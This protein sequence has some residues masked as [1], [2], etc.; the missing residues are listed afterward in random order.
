MAY[1]MLSY[2]SRIAIASGST[3]NSTTN[4][5]AGVPPP[6]SCGCQQPQRLNYHRSGLRTVVLSGCNHPLPVRDVLATSLSCEMVSASYFASCV[7]ASPDP[8][9]TLPDNLSGFFLWTAIFD[10]PNLFLDSGNAP[11]QEPLRTRLTGSHSPQALCSINPG[12]S[13]GSELSAE[14]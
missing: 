9:R 14:L 2:G 1:V 3:F 4:T 7:S 8:C 12:L 10:F 6:W 13:F 11:A 5:V